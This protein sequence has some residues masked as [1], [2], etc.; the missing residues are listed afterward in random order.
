MNE[1]ALACILYIVMRGLS[2]AK[3]LK[4]SMAASFFLVMTIPLVVYSLIRNEAKELETDQGQ[5]SVAICT[6]SF[7]YVNPGTVEVGNNI[8]LEVSGFA[9]SE[10]DKINSL[11]IKTSDN[12]VLLDKEYSAVEESITERFLFNR[13]SIGSVQILGQMGTE[14]TQHPCIINGVKD[15]LVTTQG[16]NLAPIFLSKPE[17]S[18]SPGN[19]IKVGQT[20]SYTL[21][22]KDEDLDKI[23]YSYSF[24]PRADWLSL[25]VEKDGK[26]GE[27]KI[28]FQGTPTGAA[29]YLANVF[30]HDGYNKHLRAQS[31]VISV[32][33]SNNDT[34]VVIFTQPATNVAINKGERVTV[35]WKA[36]DNNQI[37]KYRLYYAENP[38][39]KNSWRAIDENISYNVGS[40]IV[41]TGQFDQGNYKFILEAEDNQQPPAIGSAVTPEIVINAVGKDNTDGNT[42]QPPT[43]DPTTP[44]DDDPTPEPE[45]PEDPEPDDGPILLEPQIANLSPEE[46]ETI[47]NPS[48]PVG[49]TLIAGESADIDQKEILFYIDE[50]D[51][52]KESD[53]TEIKPSEVSIIYNPTTPFEPGEHKVSVYF[54]DTAGNEFSRDWNFFVVEEDEDDKS[55]LVGLLGFDISNRTI[56][57]IIIGV[58]LILLA[59]IVPWLLYLAWRDNDDPLEPTYAGRYSAEDRY[60][61]GGGNYSQYYRPPT[62]T[63]PKNESVVKSKYDDPKGVGNESSDDEVLDSNTQPPEN[64]LE[65]EAKKPV[66]LLGGV[67]S[68]FKKGSIETSSTEAI[69]S[70]PTSVPDPMAS[71]IVE[72]QNESKIPQNLTTTSVAAQKEKQEQIPTNDTPEADIEPNVMDFTENRD[73]HLDNSDT[74]GLE[75]VLESIKIAEQDMSGVTE[76]TPDTDSTLSELGNSTESGEIKNTPSK[77]TDELHEVTRTTDTQLMA[78]DP[79][80]PPYQ[81]SGV[82]EQLTAEPQLSGEVGTTTTEQPISAEV[83]PTIP[84]QS[85]SVGQTFSTLESNTSDRSIPF[86][87][88]NLSEDT[89]TSTQQYVPEPPS[90]S[91][92][93]LNGDRSES[94]SAMDQDDLQMGPDQIETSDTQSE[95]PTL[96]S[97]QEASGVPQDSLTN[98]E[99]EELRRLQESLSQLT[100][101]N[102]QITTSDAPVAGDTLVETEEPW[103]PRVIIPPTKVNSMQNGQ[104]TERGQ[105]VGNNSVLTPTDP[106]MIQNSFKAEE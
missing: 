37:V 95:T 106:T 84:D 36:T 69:V 38:G 103:K 101:E 80:T 18:A 22:A 54:K 26:N 70:E 59:I 77:L 24:T 71:T 91:D 90:L 23:I 89:S 64:T 66:G 4:I 92:Q 61:A 73:G 8:Q 78:D 50:K 85:I 46:G 15:N 100:D 42:N 20:Y 102:K 13:D 99:I 47:D 87:S 72:H 51:V 33:P 81:L 65:T 97:A 40:Y 82:T 105:Q 12:V 14:S 45:E 55:W 48:R 7:P 67:M 41:T 68:K 17:T 34:P 83:Q 9:P 28:K 79:T 96:A 104:T 1:A 74:T 57:I 31:W 19:A 62:Q 56:L 29:S 6:I 94:D 52:T 75:D 43:T 30:I 44:P 3:R 25:S 35:S 2:K 63:A 76:K 88:D 27:L 10:E 16:D 11:L 58:G 32:S 21:E 39:N 86:G 5:E 60:P 49:A 98:D 93:F 53:I